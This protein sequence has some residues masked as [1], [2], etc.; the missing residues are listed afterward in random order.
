MGRN[1]HN[2]ILYFFS[3]IYV[4]FL[5]GELVTTVK[6]H[7]VDRKCVRTVSLIRA[8]KNPTGGQVNTPGHECLGF[9]DVSHSAVRP[10]PYAD[11]YIAI[12]ITCVTM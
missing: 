3:T 12:Y 9:F 2:V 10:R 5:D 7:N 8:R 11:L 6:T 1:V 4:R